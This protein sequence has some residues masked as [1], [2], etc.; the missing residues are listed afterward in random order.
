MCFDGGLLCN[1]A[2][3]ELNTVQSQYTELN[4]VS[5]D[6]TPKKS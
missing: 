1:L 2:Q 5:A 4:E 6:N 3:E